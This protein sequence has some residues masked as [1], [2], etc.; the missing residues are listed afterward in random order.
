MGMPAVVIAA[1]AIVVVVAV[2]LHAMY[3]TMYDGGCGRGPEPIPP[4]SR[5]TQTPTRNPPRALGGV[6]RGEETGV[7][8]V[9]TFFSSR[10]M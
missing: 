1:V 4:N 10:E 3:R 5:S 8:R 6:G 9:V 7:E 2:C